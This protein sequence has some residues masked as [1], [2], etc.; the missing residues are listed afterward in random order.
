[1]TKIVEFE[2]VYLEYPD[3]LENTE[4]KEHQEAIEEYEE[5]LKGRTQKLSLEELQQKL[6][7]TQSLHL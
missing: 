4:E 7:E 6:E 1:M 3:D 5:M 2:K